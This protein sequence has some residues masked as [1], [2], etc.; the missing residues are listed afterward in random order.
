MIQ[1]TARGNITETISVRLWICGVVELTEEK[2]ISNWGDKLKLWNFNGDNKNH[3]CLV[4]YSH[5]FSE[6]CMMSRSEIGYIIFQ[7]LSDNIS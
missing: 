5:W 3:S 4:Q 2:R 7:K 1:S 6:G